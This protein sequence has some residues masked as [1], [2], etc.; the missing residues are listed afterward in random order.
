M[1]KGLITLIILA[2]GWGILR[3]QPSDYSS[4]KTAAEKYYAEGSYARAYEL[5][6]KAQSP[7]LSQ[8]EQRWVKFRVADT[9]WRSEAATQTSDSTKFEQAQQM[10]NELVR[11]I[12]REED[13]DR[14]W[15]EVQESLGDFNWM[16]RE[17]RNWGGGWGY[18]QQALDWWAGSAN[19]VE[20]RGRYLNIV[21]KASKPTWAEPYYFYGYYG[22]YVPIDVLENAAKIAKSSTDQA[23]AH[24]LIAMT[25]VRQY[26]GANDR[27]RIPREFE[28]SIA[29]GKNTDW[30]DDALFQYA[31]FLSTNG[32]II[33]TAGGMRQ[34]PDYKKALEL[35]RRLVSEFPKG[36]T[37]Y[38]DQATQAISAITS[39]VVGVSVSNI[40]LPDSE[41]DFY[42]SWRNVK[43][44]TFAL[45]KVNLND[46]VQFSGSNDSSGTW[47]QQIHPTA[48]QQ[49]KSWTKDTADKGD[50]VPGQ[51]QVHVDEKLATGAYL[52]EAKSGDK[53]AWDVIL[54]SDATL[55]LKT[56]GHQALAFFCDARNGAPIANATLSFWQRYPEGST[57]TWRHFNKQTNQD[58]MSVAEL[59]HPANSTDLFVS[60][61]VNERQ[62]FSTGYSYYYYPQQPDWRIYAFTDR[63]AY[64]PGE[65]MQWK[66]IARNYVNSIYTTPSNAV[67]E[68]EIYDPQNSKAK[69]GKLKLNQFGSAWDSLEL[70]DKMPLGEYR[71]TFYDQNRVHQ[72]G[73]ATLFRLEEYKLPE[74]KVSI[75]T[76]EE[77]GK[78]KTFVLGDQVQVNIQSDYYFGGP[79]SNATVEVVVY[80]NPY[81]QWWYPPHEYSWYYED[82]YRQQNP[83]YGNGQIMKQE[84]LKS[85][86]SGKATFLFDTPQDANQDFQYRIEARVVDASR[87][88]IT[89]SESVRVTR[90][91]YYVYPS[92]EHYLYRPEDKV[93]VNIK[94]IDAN[95]QPVIAEGNVKITRDHWYEVWLDPKGK[96]VKGEELEKLQQKSFPPNS[97]WK[98]KFRGYEHDDVSTQTI[99]TDA[100]GEAALNFTPERDGYYRVA[101]TSESEDSPIQAETTVWVAT[102]ATYDLG[103]RHGGVEIIADK[104]TFRAGQTAP[105]LL[106]VPTNDRYVLF[107]VEGDDLYS[108]QLIHVSG[109]VKLLNLPIEDKYVP[110]VFL[111]ASMVNDQQ[112]FTDEK[113]VVVPPVE[114]FLNVEVKADREEYQPQEEGT[115]TV[116]AK[117]QNGKPVSA[118]IALGLVDESVYYIQNDYAGDPREFY[119]GNKRTQQVRTQS[120]FQYRGYVRNEKKQ[121]QENEESFVADQLQAKDEKLK[122]GGAMGGVAGRSMAVAK[123]AAQNMA[124]AAEAPP[125]A[126]APQSAP[127]PEQEPAVQVRSDFRSTV[128][129]QPDVITNADGTAVVKVKYPD[130]LTG[131]KAT[132]R[133]ISSGSQFGIANAKTRTKKPL[134]V[135][136]QA[137]RFFLVGDH[138][139]VSAVINNNTDEA[140]SVTPT[141]KADGVV[142]TAATPGAL[143]V[144]ANGEARADWAVAIEQ[145]GTAKLTV[146]AR[147]SKYA[148]AMEKTYA[149]YE[150]GLEKFLSKSGKVRT[151]AVTVTLNIPKERK[152]ESTN[153]TVQITPSMAVTMLD[154]LPYLI[155]YPYGCTEQT[156]SRFLPSIITAK[157]L[158]DLHLTGFEHRLYGGIEQA[159]ADKTHPD[160]KK[161]IAKLNEMVNAGLARLYDFQHS[162]GGWGWWKEG[163]SDHFMTA[164][165]LWGL[166]LARQS[167][168]EVRSDVLQR[169]VNF[170]DNKL[171]EEEEN[172]DEQAWML[173]ALATYDASAN[174]KASSFQTKAFENI[175]KNRD[176]LN[177]Y[178]R[179]LLALSAHYFG[180]EDRAMVL[181]RNLENGVKIDKTPDTSVVMESAQSSSDSVIAT[182]HWGEDGVYWR[183]SEGP[184]ESTSFALR[185][186]LAIDPQNKL[187]EPV[188][189]WLIKN[190]RGAQW[191]NTRD[192]AIAILALNDYLRRSGELTPDVSYELLVNG[193]SIATHKVTAEDAFSAPSQFPVDRAFIKDG[194]NEIRI[195]KTSGTSPLYFAANVSFF[196]LEEPITP[197]GN[198]I[199]VRREYF[200]LVG[201]PTLLKGYVYDRVPLTD[202]G[203]VTS[204]ERIETVVTIE[205]KNDY[206]YLL[207]EDLKPAGLEAVEVRSGE[208]LYAQQLK[209]G[210]KLSG[211]KLMAPVPA[212]EN[213]DYTGESRAVYQE[214]RDRKVAMFID[215]LPQGV[216]EI[217]YTLRAE[218]PGHFHAL[219]VVGH[220]MYVPEIRCNG[221]EIRLMVEDSPQS[222]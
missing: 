37:R 46:A 52:I 80:Q 10:L 176:R 152:P 211:A 156:M 20:A 3:A 17:T 187:I 121:L 165:V 117:D 174:Q 182:A 9:L 63:P 216:W 98:L 91:R 220:A 97:D 168:T 193:R 146:T 109:M 84:T 170:L 139:T 1:R 27:N 201:K 68:Y 93:T 172:Y 194:A 153:L 104:D 83:Y 72:I 120:T 163:D 78:K 60:A 124:V 213:Q 100:S 179:A 7:S 18:Y 66:A 50:Y 82:L 214:L 192:T 196:S 175:W 127:K 22:N 177:A 155:N 19:V 143:Q 178:T 31:Q 151:D 114:H 73:G 103:Y 79:V 115:V 147:G 23:H 65:T 207:F 125:A 130:S 6:V 135:R 8:A 33:R 47:V 137:P 112:L 116:S 204:G 190:R 154:A 138:V 34:E 173:H 131:W 28:A 219:P 67:V 43:Q 198:E 140:M 32:R 105:V 87:R 40:F 202:G 205:S 188:T 197:A 88:E 209:S 95:Q 164:Y 144:P 25:L 189:N 58:G 106:S 5:Y 111:S 169:T 85:D 29:A 206:D 128:L 86:A 113:Q 150:H 218:V 57:W 4:L 148:D 195:R 181:I 45:Y 12:T 101:W 53:S 183:W 24:Y 208:S 199:F 16:R 54:V 161:D 69:E 71:V 75:Q 36:T 39:P 159:T 191:S 185:A 49:L 77:N 200:K 26:G 119:F 90:Q 123:S 186:F 132:A 118:E 44:I 99:K 215:H 145:A 184:I 142:P 203:S 96:E 167:G 217:R 56:S 64:R 222:H 134:I 51:D 38:Y 30:Y 110:N 160:G 41:I 102:N 162:D 126:P 221:S 70:N 141:L 92:P 107:S 15:A 171:V 89:A 94:A 158:H 180:S 157:T 13:K 21:W 62:A 108:Y 81:Y 166:T 133:A 14:V 35:Y 210:A 129:W 76:P 61:A 122:E 48:A 74:F 212:S 2:A 136:L 59:E 42:V 11:D 149:V 55:V